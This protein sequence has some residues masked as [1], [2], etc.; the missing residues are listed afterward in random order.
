MSIEIEDTIDHL[1]S[2][3]FVAKDKKGKYKVELFCESKRSTWKPF[4]GIIAVWR[5]G[6]ALSGSGDE[7]VYFC[8]ECGSIIRKDSHGNYHKDGKTFYGASCHE[9]GTISRGENLIDSRFA[10]LAVNDWVELLIKYY[11]KLKGD[12]DF[13]LKYCKTGIR[14][15]TQFYKD[16]PHLGK[17]R[18][19]MAKQMVDKDLVI[20]SLSSLVQDLSSGT[21]LRS[22]LR[23]FLTA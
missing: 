11:R 4:S 9:C 20:Y 18:E 14:S 8:P 5:S 1:I 10:R 13:Y 12:V 23:A 3:I 16:N 6:A 7:C 2:Q 19:N 21:S 22:A 17:A 15:T